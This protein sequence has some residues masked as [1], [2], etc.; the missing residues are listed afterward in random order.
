[1]SHNDDILSMAMHPNGKFFA[2][3]QIRSSSVYVD[4]LEQIINGVVLVH[5]F[6]IIL[7]QNP[8]LLFGL[9]NLIVWF[10][11]SIFKGLSF[12]CSL[13]QRA[14]GSNSTNTISS[15]KSQLL[16]ICTHIIRFSHHV[17]IW[18]LSWTT[19]GRFNCLLV[20]VWL[21]VYKV[22]SSRVIAMSVR[23]VN[24]NVHFVGGLLLL[25]V[26][27]CSFIKFVILNHCSI[28]VI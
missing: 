23:V 25:N 15:I 19:F 24:H 14:S 13:T 20:I 1:M 7:S 28:L 2:T 26:F 4:R 11:P 9:R 12:K 16:T 27:I 22:K 18:F 8:C 3:G 6:Y 5:S 21:W 17:L 10:L